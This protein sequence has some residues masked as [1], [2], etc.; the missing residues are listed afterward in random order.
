M[1]FCCLLSIFIDDWSRLFADTVRKTEERRVRERE[2][3]GK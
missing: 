2:R 3:Q 1:I